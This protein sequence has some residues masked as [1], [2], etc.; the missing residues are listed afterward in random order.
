M[1]VQRPLFL[2]GRVLLSSGEVPLEPI[3]IKRVCGMRTV[4]EGY[5]D[6]KGRFSFQVGGSASLA[7]MDA[8][9]GGAGGSGL[10]GGGQG[11]GGFGILPPSGNSTREIDLS[12]CTLEVDA[13]GYRSNS[14]NL[15]RRRS[16]DRSD[17]GTFILT[18]L[19]GTQS[20]AVSATSFA[21]PKKARASFDRAVKE[22]GKGP[23]ARTDKVI[24]DLDNAVTIFPEYAAAWAILGQTKSLAGDTEGAIQALEQALAADP[25][26]LRPYTTLAQLTASVANW[27]RTIELA[28]FV[29]GVNPTNSRMRWFKAVSQ[30]E[31]KNHEEAIASLTELQSDSTGAVQY[32]QSHHVLGLIYADR[33]QYGEA[34]S[35]YRRY[36]ELSPDTPAGEQLK[37]QLYEWEQLGVI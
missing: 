24:E 34:A 36:L 35:E 5:T 12:G 21:A 20:M 37:R 15:G 28:D 14:I 16:M 10:N 3:R 17:V 33:G 31:M 4:P 26:Y 7:S 32:P 13:P 22:L 25:R 19:G 30:F 1:D 18:P 9:I 6:S 2:S 29:L 8:S 23:S 27:E 11:Q